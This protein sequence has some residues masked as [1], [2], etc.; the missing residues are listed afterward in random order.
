MRTGEQELQY[1]TLLDPDKDQDSCGKMEVN[2][3]FRKPNNQNG[4]IQLNGA[5]KK[6]RDQIGLLNGN[7]SYH[8]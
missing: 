1:L 2:L 8:C 7:H 5:S 3:E 4:S 6:K